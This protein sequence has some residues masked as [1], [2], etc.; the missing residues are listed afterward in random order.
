MSIWVKV[1]WILYVLS[2]HSSESVCV[3]LFKQRRVRVCDVIT[4]CRVH[5]DTCFHEISVWSNYLLVD[6]HDVFIRDQLALSMPCKS[7]LSLN[8]VVIDT[9]IVVMYIS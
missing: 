9:I 8:A 4:V 3:S 2:L 1:A 5:L 6:S 7:V